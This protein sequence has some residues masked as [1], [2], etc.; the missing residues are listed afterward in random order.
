MDGMIISFRGEDYILE[1]FIELEMAVVCDELPDA[2]S[3]GAAG[4]VRDDEPDVEP[5][6]IVGWEKLK[7][8]YVFK[9]K[10]EGKM[11]VDYLVPIS[12]IAGASFAG[13]VSIND[14]VRGDISWGCYFTTI[15]TC[16]DFV[17]NYSF[18]GSGK[19]IGRDKLT[20]DE[21]KVLEICAANQPGVHLKRAMHL[22]GLIIAHAFSEGKLVWDDP[23][24][25]GGEKN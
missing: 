12:A 6:E 25:W 14:C 23:K 15:K 9:N 11:S 18:H 21:V 2:A 7:M 8:S 3:S 22:A 1:A 4:T 10:L 17:R 20:T 5:Y 19:V 24:F 16:K 13:P